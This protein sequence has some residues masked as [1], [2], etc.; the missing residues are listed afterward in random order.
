MAPIVAVAGNLG[1]GKS[2]VAAALARH[3]DWVHLPREGYD[4]SYIEDLFR[5]P[6]RWAF[7]A[8]MSFLYHKANAVRDAMQS[9]GTAVLDR[10]IAEDVRIFARY[11][12]EQGWMD[13]RAYDLYQDYAGWLV[14]SLAEPAV[15]VYCSA[16]VGVC[17]ARLRRRPRSYQNLYP[18]SHIA[19][20]HQMYET[21]WAELDAPIKVLID[22]AAR[23]IR[24]AVAGK[25]IAR[26]VAMALN[27]PRG[28][29]DCGSNQRFV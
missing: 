23:D 1:S 3:N 21:W 29:F 16:P 28:P 22:T 26:T 6:P 5:E 12:H 17:E 19:R 8:Q 20:L 13:E 7:E 10:S 2:T 15:V 11:F 25:E 14:A 18:P 24:D 4:V 9:P 27:A